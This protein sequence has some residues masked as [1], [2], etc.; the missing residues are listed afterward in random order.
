VDPWCCTG[1]DE[2]VQNVLIISIPDAVHAVMITWIPGAVQEVMNLTE[3]Q[4]E[5]LL[6]ARDLHNR[7]MEVLRL[8]QKEV[9]EALQV[10]MPFDSSRSPRTGSEVGKLCT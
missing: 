4:Q 6:E 9:E 10:L 3:C 1:G 2:A 7:A 8:G 5:M